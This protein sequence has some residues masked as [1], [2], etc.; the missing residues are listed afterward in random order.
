MTSLK[1]RDAAAGVHL[2]EGAVA[3]TA[4]GRPA[5]GRVRLCGRL[6]GACSILQVEHGVSDP[7]TSASIVIGGALVAKGRA[8]SLSV[9]GHWVSLG[10]FAW[11]REAVLA[12]ETTLTAD[13]SSKHV[14]WRNPGSPQSWNAARRH[15]PMMS[16]VR[17]A[18]SERVAVLK[19]V[20]ACRCR[21]RQIGTR[22]IAMQGHLGCERVMPQTQGC[23]NRREC[24]SS[25]SQTCVRM[26]RADVTAHDQPVGTRQRSHVRHG[27][28]GARKGNLGASDHGAAGS[29]AEGIRGRCQAQ[30]RR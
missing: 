6:V 11:L 18:F 27:D 20:F 23:I 22:G 15:G 5:E 21:I 19:Q 2:L 17:L 16:G 12:S 30:Q 13:D 29:C 14:E 25:P 26:D 3:A 7:A 9:T 28:V 24:R 1:M 4:V 8:Q 10:G